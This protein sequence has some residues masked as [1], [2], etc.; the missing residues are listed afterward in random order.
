MHYH[1]RA[2]PMILFPPVRE[3][4]YFWEADQFP[5]RGF[6]TRVT[7]KD[8]EYREHYREYCRH[9][10]KRYARNPARLITRAKR[11]AWDCRYLF[12]A[13]DDAWYLACFDREQGKICGEI[14]P[15]YFFLPDE[16]VRHMHELL[17]GLRIIISLREPI[18]WFWSRFRMHT[19]G[20]RGREDDE[21]FVSFLTAHLAW[22]SFSQSLRRWK[23]YFSEDQLLVLFYDELCSSPWQFYCKICH[24]LEIEPDPKRRSELVRR[25]NKGDERKLPEE[26]RIKIAKAWKDDI[27]DLATLLPGLPAC[28]KDV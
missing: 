27:E 17:P 12:G 24:F 9:F 13:H 5:N 10:V 20:G 8:N 4:R 23:K 1:L 6:F 28:W 26:F 25:V 11:L 2:H 16:Q 22:C 19:R 7:D 21:V 3:L 14:S 15:Q 18:D